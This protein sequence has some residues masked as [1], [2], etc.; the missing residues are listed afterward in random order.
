MLTTSFPV[1]ANAIFGL[2]P[3]FTKF[4][5]KA[6]APLFNLLPN[7]V[8]F[9]ALYASTDAALSKA[10]AISD[11]TLPRA[12]GL[13]PVNPSNAESAGSKENKGLA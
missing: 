12:F 10:L 11:C 1:I 6:F 7:D 13:G 5:K 2:P 4:A 8:G 3:D 9:A